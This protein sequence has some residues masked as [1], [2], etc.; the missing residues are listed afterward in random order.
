MID[1]IAADGF[2]TA[3]FHAVPHGEAK[4]GVIVIMEAFGLNQHIKELVIDFANQGYE[5]LAPALYDR[6]ERNLVFAYDSNIDN[7]IAT[8]NNNGFDNPLADVRGA[9]EFLQARG[10][11]KIAIVGYCYG[12]AVAWKA[13]AEVTGLSAAACYYGSAILRFDGIRP[14]CP[15]IA[16]WGK[17]DQSTPQALVEQIASHNPNVKMYWY[18][19]GHGF[20]SSDR[21]ASYD[22]DSAHL[23]RKR[24]L[25]FF[26]EIFSNR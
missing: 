6:I 22:K 18:D 12:G 17:S 1:I 7:V 26:N 15:T 8:M 23:A 19:A 2:A 25:L 5:A 16:H 11:H 4:G 9:V 3:A 14:Q 24:T 21:Q 10:I 20:N 13:A